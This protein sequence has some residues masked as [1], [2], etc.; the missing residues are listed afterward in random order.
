MV[1]NR[2]K[3][4]D[5][6]IALATIKTGAFK[7]LPIALLT[8]IPLGV[9]FYLALSSE[10]SLWA[11]FAQ[12]VLPP[13]VGNTLLLMVCV[14]A[15][16][17]VI[18]VPL[19]WITAVC[20]F[21]GRRFF[22]WALVL[23]LAMPAYVLAF[24]Q[25]GIFEFTGPVQSTLRLWFGPE[26]WLPDIRGSLWGLVMVLVSAFYPYVYLLCRS[27]F[28]TQGPRAMEA[29]RCLGMG[30]YRSFFKAALP[31]AKPW[32][33]GG[34][35]LVLM[36]TM[37][38]FGAV[39]V[40][41]YDTFTTAIYK[42]WFDMHNLGAATQLASILILCVL[43]LFAFEQKATK[44]QR[45]HVNNPITARSQLRG[46]QAL[47]CT[48][49][50]AATFMFTF[51]VPMLQLIAWAWQSWKEQIDMRYFEF[52]ANSLILAILAASLATML[53]LSLSWIKRR[54]P[55]PTTIWISKLGT[56]GY[57]LPG[58]VLAVGI[59]IP[60]AWLDNALG[61]LL[62]NF[63]ITE[64]QLLKGTLITM[65]LAL[66]ARFM[67]VAFQSTDSSMQRITKN[68]EDICSSLGL[69][70]RQTLVRLH[71]PLLKPGLLAAFLMVMIDVM[72][73]MPIT[74]MTRQYGWDTLAVRVYQLTSESL[75]VE[76]AS[77][78]LIIALLG[79]I[80]VIYLIGK[81]NQTGHSA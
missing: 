52:A 48:V 33:M 73:E 39:A 40:F 58:V 68:Q 64:L 28:M 80:P 38:D 35:A 66:A 31:M 61:A 63:K 46:K 20:E 2:R 70:T 7:A 1:P 8:L 34:L 67:A 79:L 51:L 57:A 29:A 41:N 37:A 11:H 26:L 5:C 78:A 56:L 81:T 72:K 25:M 16:V 74:L 6:S 45:F 54:N 9:I 15:G 10:T 50:C 43:T 3:P 42:A 4:F 19:A 44:Q 22:Q 12:Y 32:V 47:L 62:E 36:E 77:P 49:L 75:W 17:I 55:D 18:G 21:P 13:V 23:P 24:V 71:L 76:A 14:A 69:N 59:Y 60:I 53:A 30:P 27:A 65:L